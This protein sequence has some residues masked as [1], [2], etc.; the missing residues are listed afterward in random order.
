MEILNSKRVLRRERKLRSINVPIP[1]KYF[2]SQYSDESIY[3]DYLGNLIE[4]NVEVIIE[5]PIMHIVVDNCDSECLICMEKIS[6]NEEISGFTCNHMMHSM[7]LYNWINTSS[8]IHSSCPLCRN[9]DIE[10]VFN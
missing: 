4:E 3:Y 6:E 5:T 10:N 2:K 9:K 8:G 1:T 7:C